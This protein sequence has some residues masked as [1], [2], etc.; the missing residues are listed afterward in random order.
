MSRIGAV[1]K[2]EENN[3]YTINS[4]DDDDDSDRYDPTKPML[5]NSGTSSVIRVPERKLV[6]L[7]L[8]RDSF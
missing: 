8:R 3:N 5:T 2:H 1:I 7:A 6:Q 4:D